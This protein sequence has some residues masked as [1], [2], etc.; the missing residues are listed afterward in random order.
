MTSSRW[1][2][3]SPTR[4]KSNSPLC[5]PTDMRR[6]TPPADELGAPDR[7]QLAAHAGRGAHRS[8]GVVL[9]REEEQHGVA[10]PL[11][12]VPALPAGVGE[13][14]REGGVEDVAQLLGAHRAPAV[15][16]ARP[17]P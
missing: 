6:L 15:P 4:K 14:R 7:A 13:Q 10:A 17:A 9:A 16:A 12:Q 11:D 1:I 8:N 5:T 3:G 2:C